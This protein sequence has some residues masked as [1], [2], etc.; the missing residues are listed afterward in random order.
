MLS[1]PTE[2]RPCRLSGGRFLSQDA[3]SYPGTTSRVMVQ[4][5]SGSGMAANRWTYHP[6]AC[7]LLDDLFTMTPSLS[8]RPLARNLF[9]RS[10][11]AADWVAAPVLLSY[12]PT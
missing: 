9:Y 11:G 10:R 5:S 2:N 1:C 6:R 4:L 3:E 7:C 8:A 12:Y